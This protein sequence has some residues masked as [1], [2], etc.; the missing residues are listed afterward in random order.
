MKRILLLSLLVIFSIG[1][2]LIIQLD[3][4]Y[5]LISYQSVTYETTLWFAFLSIITLMIA[6]TIALKLIKRVLSSPTRIK[7]WIRY[8]QQKQAESCTHLAI[9]SFI[10]YDWRGAINHAKNAA[11]SSKNPEQMQLFSALCASLADHHEYARELLLNYNQLNL[12]QRIVDATLL[13]NEDKLDLAKLQLQQLQQENPIMR[14][15][16][17][18]Y[19]KPIKTG[20][21]AS[22]A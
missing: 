14:E 8:R 6:C 18:C 1:L 22:H 3:P 11:K 2:G 7:R 4:G 15:L 13:F 9:E 19:Y 5:L 17:A 10:Q 20:G 21:M 12:S 16:P